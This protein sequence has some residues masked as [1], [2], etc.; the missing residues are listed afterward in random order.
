MEVV[1]LLHQLGVRV[2]I[3]SLIENSSEDGSEGDDS[4]RDD[5]E[6]G[7]SEGIGLSQKEF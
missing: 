6:G 1:K 3:D 5:S 2:E 7:G 4:E